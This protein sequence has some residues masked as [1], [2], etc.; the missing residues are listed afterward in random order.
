MLHSVE[1]GPDLKARRLSM[2][3]ESNHGHRQF[4]SDAGVGKQS[5]SGHCDVKVC[6]Q[7][8]EEGFL[9]SKRHTDTLLPWTLPLL[10][11]S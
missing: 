5:H 2:T 10:Q 3:V 4:P 11:P 8:S 1:G 7:A 9:S 6:R